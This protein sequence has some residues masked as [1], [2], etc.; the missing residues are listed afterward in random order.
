MKDGHFEPD[1]DG[2]FGL[3]KDDYGP[4][5]DGHFGPDKDGFY[6]PGKWI[7]RAWCGPAISS[8]IAEGVYQAI[9]ARLVGVD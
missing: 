9:G 6:M 8:Q 1:K 7:S 3:G 4:D 5:K 2:H